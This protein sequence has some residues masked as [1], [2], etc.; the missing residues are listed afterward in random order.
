MQ[1]RTLLAGALA[2]GIGIAGCLD[3]LDDG[4]GSVDGST[5]DGDDENTGSDDDGSDDG[6]GA[7]GDDPSGTN[8]EEPIPE[9]PRVDEPPHE[10][11]R[12]EPPD[13]SDDTWNEDYL[14]EAMERTPSLDVELLERLVFADEALP[15][16]T[17][18][19]YRLTVATDAD[20]LGALIDSE[21]TPDDALGAIDDVDF[22]ERIAIVVHT[23]WG[24]GSVGHRFARVEAVDASEADE[25]FADNP[26][27]HLH[28]YYSAPYVRTS[29]WTSRLSILTVERPDHDVELARLSLTVADDR[30]VHVNSTEGVVS[31]SDDEETDE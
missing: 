5:D 23:G 15:G 24:S 22:G 28:G 9:E 13:N 29:D 6:D 14:G 30:R 2:S 17:D 20:E 4:S 27:V 18:S 26:H 1:R 3:G 8:V 31:L 19:E 12:P 25:P 10:I 7:D 16:A 11:D 21:R